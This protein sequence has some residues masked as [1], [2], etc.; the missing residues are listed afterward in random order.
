MSAQVSNQLWDDPSTN[1]DNAGVRT[2]ETEVK[3][4]G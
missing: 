4:H 1:R 2:V 3:T